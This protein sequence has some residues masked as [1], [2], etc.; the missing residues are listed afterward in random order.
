MQNPENQCGQGALITRKPCR[1]LRALIRRLENA[2]A[3]SA[4]L[5]GRSLLAP[6]TIHREDGELLYVSAEAESLLGLAGVREGQKFVEHIHVHDRVHLGQLLNRT[7]V[8]TDCGPRTAE[9]RPLPTNIERTPNSD[10]SAEWVE[11]SRFRM[12]GRSG[13]REFTVLAF[14]DISQRKAGESQLLALR[15]TAE[16]ASVA[17]S[18]FLANIS[19]ELRT[20][21]NAILG[22]SQLLNLPLKHGISEEKRTEYVSL[23]HDSATHLYAVLNDILDMSKI[24]TGKYEIFPESFNLSECVSNTVAIMRGQ[25]ELRSVTLACSGLQELPE[26]VADKRAVRQILINLLSN[27]IKF[28]DEGGRVQIVAERRARMV[29]LL[30][31]D[32]GIGMSEEHMASLG[33]PFFQADSKYDRKYEGTGLGLS[34]VKGL[35]ELHHGDLEFRSQRNVGTTVIITLPI[36][37]KAGRSV[38]GGDGLEVVDARQLPKPT[39]TAASHLRIVGT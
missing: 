38:P 28:S 35:V 6:F 10:A 8:E 39:S 32:D 2:K 24:E 5:G 26:I 12:T 7:N 9:F 29:R 37:G 18:R 23:I 11:A 27:A 3:D 19:H 20:P 15:D 33:K 34:V 31:R 1:H 22:F 30:V 21:L 17:K 4:D 36:H 13:G 25:A 14:R 16:M